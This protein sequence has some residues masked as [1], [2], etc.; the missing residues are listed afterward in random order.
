MLGITV[1]VMTFFNV[2]GAV[3]DPKRRRGK[4]NLIG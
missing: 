2:G 3:A 1:Y 4:D